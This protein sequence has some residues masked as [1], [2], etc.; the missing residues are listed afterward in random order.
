MRFGTI[1]KFGTS[2][3][4]AGM[5]LFSKAETNETKQAS[6]REIRTLSS[7]FQE[8]PF[9]IKDKEIIY[10]DFKNM[11]FDLLPRTNIEKNNELGEKS[12]IFKKYYHVDDESKLENIL[13]TEAFKLGYNKKDLEEL[14]PSQALNL[15]FKIITNSL[16]FAYVDNDEDFIKK[17]GSSLP[18]EDYLY[19]GKG[20]C[21]KYSGGLSAIFNQL[22]K[23][24]KNIN[25]LYVLDGSLGGD[26]P[27]HAWNAILAVTDK[28][29][30]L[31]HI[32]LT[33]A[34]CGEESIEARRGKHIPWDDDELKARFYK[35]VG[36]LGKSSEY[37][38]KVYNKFHMIET[39]KMALREIFSLYYIKDNLEKAEKYKKMYE[40]L[41]SKEELEEDYNY[42]IILMQYSRLKEDNI[43]KEKTYLK[44]MG[45]NP[46]Y[47]INKSGLLELEKEK[48]IGERRK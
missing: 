18:I 15:C 25:N 21:D 6:A 23:Y 47:M 31:T 30:F 29:I 28:N 8:L 40:N 14:A 37:F 26:Y 39:K 13:I 46:V 16:D 12:L 9:S 17:Y 38:F 2:L 4:F 34:D 35:E 43:N 3:L 48:Q 7:Y 41:Y 10:K 42:K 19:I 27:T 44:N 5:C 1:S 33:W 24:N 32:D 45:L 36:E 11:H 20:D 22:K